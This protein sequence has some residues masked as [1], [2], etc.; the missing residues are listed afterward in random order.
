MQVNI[1]GHAT[2]AAAHTLFSSGLV[3][4]NVIEFVTL[5]GVLTA[6]RIQAINISSISN[7]QNGETHDG[8]YVELDF[9]A[10]PIIEPK[11]A[12]TSEIS[13]A[14]NGASIIDI[15]STQIADD[16]LV[17]LK[18]ALFHFIICLVNINCSIFLFPRRQHILVMH[19]VLDIGQKNTI[20]YI[21]C[22]YTLSCNIACVLSIFVHIKHYV[23]YHFS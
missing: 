20:Y 13:T 9:P 8:F 23:A 12:E 16:L 15:K 1:C 5:S 17:I 19:L 7:L 21:S 22:Y 10:Y 18:S 4:G 3:D 2:L 14:L 11:F 6:K